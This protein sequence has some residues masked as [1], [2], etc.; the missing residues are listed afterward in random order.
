MEKL[1]RSE[2]CS[3][4]YLNSVE[5]D[6]FKT[7]KISINMSMPLKEKTAAEN[8]LLIQLLGRCCREYPDY[9]SLNRKINSLYGAG[10]DLYC[11]KL[12][13][14]QVLTLSIAGLDDRYTLEGEVL[15]KEFVELLC[16]MI[17]D[18]KLDGEA[19]S[20]D[21]VEQ[22]RRQLLE[23][24]EAETNEKRSYAIN[25]CIQLM[26][27]SSNYGLRRYGSYNAVQAVTPHQL[28]I[29]WKNLISTATININV[30]GKFNTDIIRE[31]FKAKFEKITRKPIECIIRPFEFDK[32]IKN[33]I[34][35]QDIMQ[36]KLVMGFG[37]NINHT[38][39]N[40]D[41]A[42]LMSLILG[43][44][45]S[46]KLF[47]NVREKKSLCYYCSASYN[48]HKDIIFVDCGVEKQN[49]EKAKKEILNQIEQ[50]KDGNI[51]DFEIQAAKLAV[52]DNMGTVTDTVSGIEKFYSFQSFDKEILTPD[53]KAERINRVTKQQI[54]D[55]ANCVELA[56][57]Y[58][59]TD[60]KG[61]IQ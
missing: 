25:Q 15:S 60:N 41:T 31:T 40:A 46:S 45:P 57:V 37:L 49:I 3:G 53:Q 24:I 2:I 14:L 18:P 6:R 61:D 8:A 59:L 42:K 1:N 16:K 20:E 34:E 48:Y 30:I 50:I 11:S 9:I 13:D 55:I 47:I 52:S 51:S 28:Y 58:V 44:I 38:S 36:S 17:F 21:D 12:G 10:L 43:G 29:A 39:N 22:E 26:C 19:F 35:T 27:E 33:K 56:A 23:T 4:I 32:K 54:I 5:D 7:G